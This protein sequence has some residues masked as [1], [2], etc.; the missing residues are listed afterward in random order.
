[1]FHKLVV[2][3]GDSGL[4]C[5]NRATQNFG[6]GIQFQSDIVWGEN[7]TCLWVLQ[8]EIMTDEE[9]MFCDCLNG[10]IYQLYLVWPYLGSNPRSTMLVVI[11]QTITP[12][13]WLN[14]VTMATQKKDALKVWNT[15]HQSTYTSWVYRLCQQADNNGCHSSQTE[16]K[17]RKI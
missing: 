12:P 17:D 10:N 13:M 6:C 9:C 2:D 11:T 3:R 5:F 1:M 8:A 7:N 16:S 15:E 4:E 14:H